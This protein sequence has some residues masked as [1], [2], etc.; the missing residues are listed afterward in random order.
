MLVSWDD[1][2]SFEDLGGDGATPGTEAERTALDVAHRVSTGVLAIDLKDAVQAWADGKPNYGV[3]LSPLGPDGVGFTTMKSVMPPTLTARVVQ[4]AKDVTTTSERSTTP[5]TTTTKRAQNEDDDDEAGRDDH[6][7]D[8]ADPLV[9]VST[10]VATTASPTTT[11]QAQPT[12]T[13]NGNG[14]RAEFYFDVPHDAADWAIA[15]AGRQQPDLIRTDPDVNCGHGSSCWNGV[16]TNASFAAHWSGTLVLQEGGLYNF[17]VRSDDIAE[18]AVDGEV[19]LGGEAA[20]VGLS[21][22]LLLSHKLSSKDLSAGPHSIS[23]TLLQLETRAL[24]GF[25]CRYQGPDTDGAM[26]SLPQ[27][28]LRPASQSAPPPSQLQRKFN[29]GPGARAA[30]AEV[31]DSARAAGVA[32]GAVLVAGLL[33]SLAPGLKLALDPWRRA[34]HIRSQ[35]RCLR[36]YDHLAALVEGGAGAGGRGRGL[37][38]HVDG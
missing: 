14:L 31:A 9:I 37:E 21:P 4:A 20:G 34:W 8:D 7:D 38:M 35:Q 6:S 2:T 15:V 1:S 29:A 5:E 3:V 27:N 23:I 25:D 24:I 30:A 13:V 16:R 11:T 17:E 12:G 10:T 26:V 19:L 28:A 18:L 33:I 32:A 22:L 36:R